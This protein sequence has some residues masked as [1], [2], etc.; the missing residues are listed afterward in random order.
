MGYQTSKKIKKTLVGKI[1]NKKGGTSANLENS[2]KRLNLKLRSKMTPA[3]LKANDIATSDGASIW[4]LSLPLKHESFSL[5]KREFFDA[6]LLRYGWKLKRLPH[7]CLCM[8]QYNIYHCKC[9]CRYAINGIQ[10]C[11][12]RTSIKHYTRQ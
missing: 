3:Q 1:K 9:H 2:R 10:R 7:K 8:A 5:T 12:E 4:L 6:F 11:K